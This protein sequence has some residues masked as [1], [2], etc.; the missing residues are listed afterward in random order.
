MNVEKRKSTRQTHHFQ[1]FHNEQWYYLMKAVTS[2]NHITL[3]CEQ[4]LAESI[5]S[6]IWMSLTL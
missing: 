6:A 2:Q 4:Q 3:P 1:I 5:A